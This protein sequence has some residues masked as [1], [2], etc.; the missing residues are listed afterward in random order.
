MP[1]HK[2]KKERLVLGPLFKKIAPTIG[3]TVFLEPE[4]HIAGCIVFKSGQ[5]SYFRYNTIDLNPVGSAD[6]SRDKDYA[7]FFMKKLGY[8]I[9]PGSKT[10]YSDAWAAAVGTPNR[11]IDYAYEHAHA[12]GFP[13]V[14][15]PNS[16]SQGSGVRFAHTK[17]DFYASM[18]SIFKRDRVALVQKPVY[19]KDFRLVVLDDELISAYQ[20]V[21]LNVVGDGRSTIEKLFDA[22]L[23]SYEKDNRDCSIKLD[24]VRI[25]AKLKRLKLSITSVP[26]RDERI[27]LLDNA[28]LSTGGESI[29][30]T[31]SVHP[32]FK[33]T[34]IELTKNMG[35]RF[36]GVDLMIDGEITE[37]PV[38]NKWFVLE[39]NAAP[40]LDHYVKTGR[41]QER[42][43]EDLYTKV[44]KRIEK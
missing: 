43:V 10:F 18:R 41:E 20:R 33:A 34:A 30:V 42:I 9:V 21:P 37:A 13:V 27:F 28:N 17:K 11:T 7:N 44:L 39:T 4:W 5:R 26:A 38:P 1:A 23:H 16:G 15:K 2:P 19:G 31:D 14:V 3:A 6:I 25:Q 36:C 40:G 22:K 24:D 29:D 35:L 8:P 12:I 32:Q